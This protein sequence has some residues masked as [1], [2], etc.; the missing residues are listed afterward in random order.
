MVLATLSA[1]GPTSGLS[2]ALLL[3]KPEIVGEK[4]DLMTPSISDWLVDLHD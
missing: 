2:R 3:A 1:I 4:S